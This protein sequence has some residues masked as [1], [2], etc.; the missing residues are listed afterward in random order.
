MNIILCVDEN[1]GML[2]NK[3]R[4]S[5][6]KKVIEDILQMTDTLW[7]H[8]FSEKLF[9]DDEIQRVSKKDAKQI[10]TDDKFLEKALPGQYC[11]VENQELMLYSNNI[12]QIVLYCWNRKYPSDFKL[13]LNLS[14]WEVK[15]VT[16]F[17]GNSH[18]KIT[19]TIYEKA[20]EKHDWKKY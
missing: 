1:M 10:L 14:K 17:V 6:D 19:K 2:F 8:P 7:I 16:E 12:E 11:F 18:K 15:K 9:Q 13:D 3:R 5:S 20:G 4:Q